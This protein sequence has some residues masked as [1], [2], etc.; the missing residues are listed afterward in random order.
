MD[1]LRLRFEKTGR[2]VWISHLDLMH[3]MQRAFS[4][5][6]Y[7]LKYSEGF[8]PHPQISI[9]LPLSVGVASFC[10]IMDF[11]LK[12]DADLKELPAR[13]T[14]VMPEGIRVTDCYEQVSKA[15]LLKYLEIEGSFEYDGRDTQEMAQALTD[16]YARD[17]IVIT[18]KTKR[19]VG[20]SDIRPAV[21]DIAFTPGEGEVRLRAVISAQE[22]TLNPA[23]L[24]D[25]LRQL[26]PDIAPDFEK[27]TRLENYLENMTVFR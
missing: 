27:F 2:A 23:L 4:R 25:A 17:S 26:K 13:L 11:R 19:G 1:K 24:A 8:N 18:K 21:R 5:A 20:E 16:F 9:A 15:A 7:A 12:T 10:E 6:G 3:T 22:P 14:A